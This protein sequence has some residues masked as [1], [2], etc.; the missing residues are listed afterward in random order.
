MFLFMNRIYYHVKNCL[1]LQIIS[2]LLC[3]IIFYY[4]PFG[5]RGNFFSHLLS[6]II[7]VPI[8]YIDL[9]NS[10]QLQGILWTSC[11][12]TIPIALL[13]FM[14]QNKITI[15][16][17]YFI[18]AGIWSYHGYFLFFFSVFSMPGNG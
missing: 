15:I 2:I 6:F 14:R 13:F 12:L 17:F 18:F 8:S 9:F 10:P 1:I 5:S 16:L 3:S 7:Y 4:F 11:V